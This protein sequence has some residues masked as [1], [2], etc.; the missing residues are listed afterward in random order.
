MSSSPLLA[1]TVVS[2]LVGAGAAWLTVSLT[3]PGVQPRDVARPATEPRPSVASEETREDDRSLATSTLESALAA[4][5][6]E[7]QA[8]KVRLLR[9]ERQAARV[10][11]ES[12]GPETALAP[13]SALTEA[14]AFREGVSDALEEIRAAE[15]AKE[16]ERWVALQSEKL[17]ERIQRISPKLGLYP[18][19]ESEL[20]AIL[21][22]RELAR[23]EINELGEK[24]GDKTATRAALRAL[25]ET[26]DEQLET[27]L[28]PVQLE[29]Y[30]EI[31][32]SR[33]SKRFGTPTSGRKTKDRDARGD[34]S[35]GDRKR[36]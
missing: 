5:Q 2:A 7:N 12:S 6:E 31:E 17:T 8:L 29:G 19:Q 28:T 33:E 18:N 11:E 27:L 10:P 21:L 13:A 22:D 23:A 26:S 3:A 20:H 36:D 25:K 4:L 15:A 16:K 24:H 9:L 1:A 34:R 30:R 35:K 32:G 14:P